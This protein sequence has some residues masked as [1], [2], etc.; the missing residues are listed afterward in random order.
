MLPDFLCIGAMKAGTTW[1]YHNVK[2]HPDVEMP[3]YK[4]IFYF[5]DVPSW[6]VITHIVRGK[7]PARRRRAW[8][9]LTYSWPRNL[10][11]TRW[12]LRYLFLPRNDEWYASLFRREEG[13]VAGDITP[14][15]ARL[16]RRRVA[17]V[18]NLLPDAKIIYMLRNP[19]KLVWSFAAMQFDRWGRGLANTGREEI[20]AFFEGG[21]GEADANYLETLSVWEAFYPRDQFYVAFLDAVAEDPFAVL[22]GL[23]RFLGLETEGISLPPSV[24]QREHTRRYPPMPD[25]VARYLAE[26]YYPQIEKL[27]QRFDNRYTAGWL[28]YAAKLL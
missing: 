3:P 11:H 26:T 1:L 4:E 7:R 16:S 28:E 22:E 14:T 23:Y 2:H 5:H 24:G 27:H 10:R 19:I 18:R 25:D 13:K 9:A 12:Y 21:A 15:Y 6:P 20:Q 8:W 17:N